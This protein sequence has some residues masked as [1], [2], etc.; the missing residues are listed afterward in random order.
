MATKNHNRSLLEF[1]N[2]TEVQTSP[3]ALES[4]PVRRLSNG[5][6][7][8]IAESP[9]SKL[10][11]CLSCRHVY[12]VTG[13]RHLSSAG[14]CEA[15]GLAEAH[16]PP[17]EVLELEYP[18]HLECYY[19]RDLHPID[20]I[21]EYTCLEART[22]GSSLQQH[23]HLK[24]K[25]WK[26]NRKV[27]TA[28][29][30]HPNFSF[31]VFRMVMKLYRQGKDCDKLLEFLAYQSGAVMEGAQ[32]KQVIATPKIVG[33]RLLMR[34]QTAYVIPPKGPTQT[35]LLTG[36]LLKCPH[37]SKWSRDNRIVTKRLF[38][39]FAA[40]ET[41][42][43]VRQE[44]I[45]SCQCAFCPTEFHFG[46]EQFEGQGIVLFITKWQDLGDGLSPLDSDFPPV[47]GRRQDIRITRRGERLAYESPRDRFEGLVPGEDLQAVSALNYRERKEL[48][49]KSDS[50]LAQLRK[51]RDSAFWFIWGSGQFH[52]YRV[53]E[54]F[55]RSEL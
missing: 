26:M 48:F 29:F 2:D 30:I 54:N 25:C 1:F 32:V 13:T 21:R 34:L 47:V 49:R 6:I 22:Q 50:K 18:D 44:H 16:N 41:V 12:S 9:A 8:H 36:N 53:S 3:N 17:W 4:S 23:N 37:T 40:L 51:I 46:L 45:M 20:K 5:T 38:Q 28:R 52:P 43:V 39:R 35:Y 14:V 27:R 15:K 55:A 31:T 33:E 42:S 7:L 11:F 24:D 10:G 19:C